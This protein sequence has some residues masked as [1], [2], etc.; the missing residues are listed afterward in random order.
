MLLPHAPEP[1]E[2]A[3]WPFFKERIT[4][5]DLREVA[6]VEYFLPVEAQYRALQ[7][8]L[9]TGRPAS[10][11]EF[12]SRDSRMWLRECFGLYCGSG[13][14]GPND[15]E[16]VAAFCE[17]QLLRAST[18]HNCTEDAWSMHVWQLVRYSDLV[19]LELRRDV[20]AF[21]L[22]LAEHQDAEEC[23]KAFTCLIAASLLADGKQPT[24]EFEA[25]IRAI[26]E[27]FEQE[28]RYWC[29]GGLSYRTLNPD[30]GGETGYWLDTG[31]SFI[32]IVGPGWKPLQWV[33]FFDPGFHTPQL[34]QFILDV[35]SVNRH[36]SPLIAERLRWMKVQPH[37]LQ[38]AAEH[39]EYEDFD[40]NP[41]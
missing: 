41:S 27:L 40:N 7:E 29:R 36:H 32:P 8:M 3:L 17:W 15:S 28:M 31:Q 39:G 35:F 2:M 25:N 22:W 12:S 26:D 6:S 11:L 38:A 30:G 14:L 21:L 24:A 18:R 37:P 4:D 20:V 16:L 23:S 13:N 1:D 33:L 10:L 5:D 9:D 34:N 19:S